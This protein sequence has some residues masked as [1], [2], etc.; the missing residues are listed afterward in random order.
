LEVAAE[1]PMDLANSKLIQPHP[2]HDTVQIKRSLCHSTSIDLVAKRI[3]FKSAMPMVE[4]SP[5]DVAPYVFVS[6]CLHISIRGN[7]FSLLFQ[8]LSK[9]FL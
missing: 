4:G 7:S 1:L 2:S 9:L 3:G 5:F 8:K 6:E